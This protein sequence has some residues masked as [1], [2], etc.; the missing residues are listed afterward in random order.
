M[1]RSNKKPPS[2]ARQMKRHSKERVSKVSE[3]LNPDDLIPMG[4]TLLNLAMSDTIH[5]GAKKGTMINIIGASHGGKTV[6]ALTSF[7]E[8][9]MKKSF[10]DYSFIYDDVE[11][12]NSFNMEYLFGEEATVRIIP[13]RQDK[14]DEF[15][16]TVQHFHANILHLLEKEKPFLYVLDSYDA[17][18]ALEDQKKVQ[19]MAQAL[20]NDTKKP[21][22][23]YGMAK[24]K[25]S[26]S[27]LRSITNQLSNSKSALFI[28]SQT[29]D[30]V[31]PMSPQKE[32]RSG[33]R[34]LKFYAHHE[35]WL[36]QIKAIKRKDTIIGGTIRVRISKNKLTG[37]NR[38]IEFDIYTDYG[39]DDIGSCID[40]LLKIGRW[41]GGG[42]TKINHKEDFGFPPY[43][44]TK[45][46]QEIE[47]QNLHKKL[48]RIVEKEWNEF[49]DSLKLNRR[50][51]YE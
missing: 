39:I 27:I 50:N 17:L 22:G 49:E 24:A 12:A 45:M 43:T 19:E 5:G 13:P 51:K 20:E 40:Y 37:K 26:S 11:R 23:T 28:V 8:V 14:E 41:S 30:N 42:A 34:A 2:L 21:A 9:N 38:E 36:K 32:T 29:R 31:D 46:I 33:G 10:D 7:A 3:H 15:S 1:E 4:S 47:K 16:I 18:D 35:M 25:A 44:K 6:L 48:Q